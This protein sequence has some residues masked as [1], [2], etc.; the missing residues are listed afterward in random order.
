M[1][2]EWKSELRVFRQ[3]IHTGCQTDG[4]VARLGGGIIRIVLDDHNDDAMVEYTGHTSMT[5]V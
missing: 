3:E 2:C 5:Q 4:G 1:N